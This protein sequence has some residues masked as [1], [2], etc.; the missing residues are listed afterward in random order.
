MKRVIGHCFLV[1]T[2]CSASVWSQS[3]PY[4]DGRPQARLRLNAEDHGVVL[5]HGGGPRGCDDLGARDVW[6][7][8]SGGTYHMHY[9]AAGALGWLCALATSKDL[10][11][12]D[13]KGPVLELGAPGAEDAKSASYGV[14]YHEGKT[15]HMFYLGTPNTS[16][17]PDRVPAFPYMTMK[18]RGES[19]AGPWHKQPEVAPFRPKLGTYYSVTA[20]P[21]HVVKH[22]GEYLQFFSAATRDD[23]KRITRRT[24]SIAR[25][26][27]LD[28]AWAIDTEPIVP[29]AEQIENSSLYYEPANDTWF[30]F[31]NHIGIRDRYEYTDAI[32]VYWTK[33]LNRWRAEDKAIVLDSTN[34]K[35]SPN[36]IGLPSVVEHGKRLAIFYDGQA[37]TEMSHMRRDVGLAFLKLP[38]VPPV[39]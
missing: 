12:W 30:L 16:P 17:A 27:D 37:G 6:V 25:T 19:A 33:D 28:G 31:T 11:H 35:W 22:K 38:L 4:E 34:C 23:E 26:R 2:F 9:D 20:S 24:L 7:Y 13:K 3:A 29:L 21:G 36:I 10:I 39:P 8:E 14:T 18:A 32:W 1:W 15:W 5:K